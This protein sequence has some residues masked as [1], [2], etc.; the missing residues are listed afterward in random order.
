M[1][2]ESQTDL[3]AVLLVNLGTPDAYDFWNV[4]KYL[5][6]FLSD[7]R[8][9]EL[10]PILWIPILHGYVLTTRPQKTGANYKRI[11]NK[12]NNESPLLSYTR[13]QANKLNLLFS[14]KT[15]RLQKN[16]K[17]YWAMRYGNPSINSALEKI[18]NDRCSSILLL[19]LFPQYSA[20]TTASI[21]DDFFK[22]LRALR[23]IPAIQ[24]ISSFASHPAYIQA[25][26]RSI[27]SYLER[28]SF[29]PQVL[30]ASFHGIPKSYTEK[31]DPYHMECCKTIKALREYMKLDESKLMIS[32]QSR[33]GREEWLQPYTDKLVEQ[34]T[35]QSIT[36]IAIF[37]PGFI[38]DCLETLDEIAREVKEVFISHGGTHF[39]H[40]PC[41]ND[42]E[43]AINM[44]NSLI[45]ENCS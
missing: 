10:N 21:Y 24:T 41:L 34:L 11:W 16:I 39:A 19:P 13:S 25:L 27:Y 5:K 31:G 7:K 2:E 38:S 30:V 33:F 4:R 1:H 35:K 15:P 26:A 12:Q 3:Q 18:I 6:Q 8:I 44:L 14:S 23:N 28:C 43:I 20:T 9:I 40:I 42:S 36:K 32:F 37:N 17:V 29:E 45:D 22:N